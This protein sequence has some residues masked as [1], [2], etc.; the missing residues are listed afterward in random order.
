VDRLSSS[1]AKGEYRW[2]QTTYRLVRQRPTGDPFSPVHG[3]EM[4]A[5]GADI[6]ALARRTEAAAV[7][8]LARARTREDRGLGFAIALSMAGQLLSVAD[9]MEVSKHKFLP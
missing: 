6:V 8:R 3:P 7:A 5:I 9:R 4:T 2:V 1:T